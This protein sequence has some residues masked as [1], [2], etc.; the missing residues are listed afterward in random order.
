MLL[1]PFELEDKCYSVAFKKIHRFLFGC[2]KNWILNM[3][4]EMLVI[5][6][7]NRKSFCSFSLSANINRV[8]MVIKPVTKLGCPIKKSSLNHVTKHLTLGT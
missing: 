7:M 1:K 8:C 2:I 5:K 6:R 3:V 4:L